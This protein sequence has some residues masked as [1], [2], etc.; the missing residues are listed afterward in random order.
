MRR[1]VAC[2]VTV[3]VHLIAALFVGTSFGSESSDNDDSDVE[4]LQTRLDRVT[5]RLSDLEDKI[6]HRLDPG[7]KIEARSFAA[8]LLQLEDDVCDKDHFRCGMV[9]TECVSHLFVCDGITDCRNGE[10]EKHCDAPIHSGDIF[11]GEQVFDHCGQVQPENG[12][13]TFVLNS[14]KKYDFFTPRLGI[15]ATFEMSFKDEFERSDYSTPAKGYYNFATSS[16]VLLAP[17]GASQGLICRFDGHN[18]DKCIGET[19]TEG[20]LEACAKY[21]YFRQE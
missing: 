12:Q 4:L 14:V 7:M 6:D 5:S 13:I 9:D 11:R 3:V 17:K 16:I 2:V 8:R 21:V 15:R 10:D 18:F 20:S 19:T 1:E